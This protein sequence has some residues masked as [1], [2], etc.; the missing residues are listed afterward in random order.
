MSVENVKQECPNPSLLTR[1]FSASETLGHWPTEF[2]TECLSKLRRHYVA[3]GESEATDRVSGAFS[4]RRN[5][6][7]CAVRYR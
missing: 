3:S 4:A 2:F 7:I 5:R 1:G 6:S